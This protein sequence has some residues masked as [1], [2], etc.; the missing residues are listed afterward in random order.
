M[1]GVNNEVKMNMKNPLISNDVN[2]MLE[3]GKR[4]NSIND[5]DEIAEVFNNENIPVFE[6]V[7]EF[8]K[9]YGGYSYKIG[10]EFYY[11]FDM[12]IF[13]YDFYK[14]R[15]KFRYIESDENEKKYFFQCMDFH[16]AGDIGP[17]IDDIGK[18]YNCS[19][20]CFLIRADSIEEFLED[21]AIKFYFV[22]KQCEWFSKATPNIKIKEFIKDKEFIQIEKESFSGKYFEWW[23]D[24]EEST[25]IRID[26]GNDYAE[27]YCKSKEIMNALYKEKVSSII[28][29]R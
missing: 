11:G 10:K 22:K 28:Y 15:F 20:G 23:I 3:S 16:F 25:F 9:L 7:V 24:P 13:Y 19:M 21:E 12:N 4:K 14:N 2:E 1:K 8:Q 6:K 26:L 29:P 18:I 27:V 17:C 5:L